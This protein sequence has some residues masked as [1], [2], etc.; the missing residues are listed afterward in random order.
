MAE[1]H[2]SFLSRFEIGAPLHE[3]AKGKVY[4]AKDRFGDG[5][6]LALKRL[7]CSYFKTEEGQDQF[8][9]ELQRARELAHPN[10][11]A[12]SA[13]GKEDGDLVYLYEH[14]QG[15]LLEHRSE[16]GPITG[17]D[18]CEIMLQVSAALYFVH[19]R[20][21]RHAS[22]S[23][24]NILLDPKNQVKLVDVG[25]SYQDAE[26]PAATPIPPLA[27]LAAA[28]SQ[29][30]EIRSPE[31]PAYYCA[32]LSHADESAQ[33]LEALCQGVWQ[34]GLAKEFK[35]LPF[36]ARF[37]PAPGALTLRTWLAGLFKPISGGAHG[38]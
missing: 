35:S 26:E 25:I 5:S 11:L 2:A 19:S 18:A 14:C 32:A 37:S 3:G 4:L 7:P 17:A 29:G 6:L 30:R 21:V 8:L 34:N 28:L 36:Y 31:Y 13:F 10:I 1:A 16:S 22:L 9:A 23:P 20:G 38:E 12:I 24:R 15:I 27:A 33:F